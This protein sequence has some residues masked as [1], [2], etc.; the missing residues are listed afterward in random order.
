MHLLYLF[1]GP[2]IYFTFGKTN[3]L[4]PI[5]TRTNPVGESLTSSA[6]EISVVHHLPMFRFSEMLGLFD[7]NFTHNK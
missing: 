2:N 4:S 7:R 1:N 5:F 3:A 6:P